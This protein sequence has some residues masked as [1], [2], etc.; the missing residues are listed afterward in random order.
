MPEENPH[1]YD[2]RV[3]ERYINKGDVDAKDYTDHLKNLPD[4]ADSVVE[5]KIPVPGSSTS[6]LGKSDGPVTTPVSE[7]SNS[8]G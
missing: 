2:I 6:P 5:L 1:L 3:V 7:A 4:L 8:E